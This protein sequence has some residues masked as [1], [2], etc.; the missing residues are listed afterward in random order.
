MTGPLQ[1]RVFTIDISRWEFCEG[2]TETKLEEFTIY[3]YTPS[4][5][6]GNL[7]GINESWQGTFIPM[8]GPQGPVNAKPPFLALAPTSS[9]RLLYKL[10]SIFALR[11]QLRS[12]KDSPPPILGSSQGR[13]AELTHVQIPITGSYQRLLLHLDRGLPINYYSGVL[14]WQSAVRNLTW[15]FW[16]AKHREHKERAP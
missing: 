13:P 10:Q 5:V 7:F 11:K 15:S 3:V 12:C 2:K 9:L 8:G 14:H 1:Q 4:K 6:A 16:V